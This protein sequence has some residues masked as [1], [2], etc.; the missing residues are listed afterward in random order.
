MPYTQGPFKCKD[1]D[2][3]VDITN[4]QIFDCRKCKKEAIFGTACQL[5]DDNG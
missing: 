3:T 1:Y 5:P 2:A 4:S